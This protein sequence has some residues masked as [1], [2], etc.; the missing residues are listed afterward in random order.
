MLTSLGSFSG[1]EAL[2]LMQHLQWRELEKGET[3]LRAGEVCNAIYYLESGACYQY[4]GEREKEEVTDLHLAGE[5]MFVQESLV[6]QRASGVTLQAFQLSRVA[7][8]GLPQ[9][10][11]LMS[12]GPAFLQF[13]RLFNQGQERLQMFDEAMDPME[14]YTMLM[15]ARPQLHAVFPVKMIASYLKLAPETLSRVRARFRIS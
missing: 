6:G 7:V 9:L 12:L 8:L 1:K 4:K 13:G 5:W 11:A 10:H 15:R 3:L 14:K 2:W